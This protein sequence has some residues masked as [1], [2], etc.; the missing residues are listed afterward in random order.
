M[1]QNTVAYSPQQTLDPSN[2]GRM[3]TQRQSEW[4]N[5]SKIVGTTFLAIHS[6]WQEQ[7]MKGTTAP[8]DTLYGM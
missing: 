5:P 6:G 2:K 8:V 4:S 1:F 7:G 3:R